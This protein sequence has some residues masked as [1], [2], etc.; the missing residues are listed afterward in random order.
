[1][2]QD[3][4]LA[5]DEARRAAQ[6][7][8]VKATLQGAVNH[9]VAEEGMADIASERQEI[10]AL[11]R[12]L[13]HRAVREV[14]QSERQLAR[15]RTSARVRQIVDYVFFVCYGLIVFEVVLEMAG[16]RESSGF[17]AAIDTVTWP[18]LAP[19]R[20]LFSDLAVGQYRFMFSFMAALVVWLS[21]H[22]AIR[23]LLR[24]VGRRET[25]L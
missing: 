2:P 20:G 25:A 4:K 11:G 6:H 13:D 8:S 3:T 21:V 23:G 5:R 19:F 7:R 10:G 15:T 1:M 16:A 12:E 14:A 24:V 22:M 17:K 18:L 9:A